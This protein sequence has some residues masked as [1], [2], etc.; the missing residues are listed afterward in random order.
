MVI[1]HCHAPQPAAP[2]QA[3]LDGKPTRL[4]VIL[5]QHLFAKV[6]GRQVMG[7][8]RVCPEEVGQTVGVRRVGYLVAVFV[9]PD[10]EVDVLLGLLGCKPPETTFLFRERRDQPLTEESAKS[11][12]TAD[13][14]K[15]SIVER[16]AK[17]IIP[18]VTR[19]LL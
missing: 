12:V 9:D 6:H 19:A 1:I 17:Q 15:I 3:V 13:T 4:L 8:V 5:V 10:Y 16:R 14:T 2:K 11:T 7:H 18:L